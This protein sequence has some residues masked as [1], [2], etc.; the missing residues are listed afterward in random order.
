MAARGVRHFV[1]A[2]AVVAVAAYI[3]IYTFS[4]ADAPIRSDGYSYYVYLPATFIY[5]DP[6]LEALSR[7]WY[8]GAFPDFTAIRRFPSTGRWL[9]AC[10]IGA[11]LLMFPFFGVGHLLSWWSNLPRDGFSFYYQH[12]AGLAG[13][14]YFLCGL[15]IVRSML[16]RRFSEGVVLATLVALT[17]GTNLFH[18]GT[19]DATFSHAFSF[20]LICSLI[21]LVERWW[22]RPAAL[23]SAALGAVAGLIVLTRNLNAIFLL[24]LPLY[25]IAALSDMRRRMHALW[26][27][28][29]TLTLAALVAIGVLLPQFVLYKWTTGSWIVNSY[30]L[31]NNRFA[32]ESPHLA[33]VLFS[34]QKGLFFWSPVLLL[35][36]V[37][38]FVA[39]G[40]ARGLVA[41][42]AIVFGLQAYIVASWSDWQLGGSYGSRA[43]TDGLG[44]AAP[45]VAACFEWAAAR[46]H[47]HTLIVAFAAAAVLLSVVQMIQY[48]NG[49]IPFADTTWA[50]YRSVFLRLR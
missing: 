4:F 31:L 7:D 2:T 6:S 33:S 41:A 36:V 18:Y 8:G 14:T 47:V 24:L 28:R 13:V 20:F 1:A 49:I 11:A 38:A 25:G 45:L 44:L 27:R 23:R 46:R 16:R 5:A 22:E 10:P 21:A 15:A 30:Q 32:F 39:R 37:G 9:D 48:W 26:Q 42:A 17:W 12:A 35:A 43:F 19:F 29:A 34:T 40:W 3:A 50:Q